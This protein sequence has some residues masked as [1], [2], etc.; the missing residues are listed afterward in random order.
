M[1][2]SGRTPGPSPAAEYTRDP[3]PRCQARTWDQ[4]PAEREMGRKRA[5]AAGRRL[6]VTF[7]DVLWLQTVPCLA[8]YV[9]SPGDSRGKG[10]PH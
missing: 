4:G 1:V 5:A 10:G 7:P 6:R 8:L 2:L 9:G 3:R